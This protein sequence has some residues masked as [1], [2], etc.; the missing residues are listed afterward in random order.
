MRSFFQF[1]IDAAIGTNKLPSRYINTPDGLDFPI[2]PCF[3]VQPRPKTPDLVRIAAAFRVNQPVA[4]AI[5]SQMLERLYQLAAL[6]LIL[7]ERRCEH[8]N[9]MS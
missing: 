7:K 4:A 6:Q 5:I 1:C 9:A 8:C 2:G 3:L